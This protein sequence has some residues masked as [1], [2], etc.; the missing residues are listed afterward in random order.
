MTI[1][2]TEEEMKKKKKNHF[3]WTVKKECPPN[4]KK[5]ILLKLNL[6]KKMDE[7]R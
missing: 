7:P 4:I 2:F 3:N 1:L 6:L 5:T